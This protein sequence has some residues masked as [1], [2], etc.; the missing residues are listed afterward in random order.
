MT[1]VGLDYKK[2]GFSHASRIS[3]NP[4]EVFMMSMMHFYLKVNRNVSN[5]KMS[6]I[7]LDLAITLKKCATTQ[8]QIVFTGTQGGGNPRE[9]PKTF[10]VPPLL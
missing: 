3:T 8:G 7:G 1:I 6:K 2:S 4:A 9:A 10:L 5:N